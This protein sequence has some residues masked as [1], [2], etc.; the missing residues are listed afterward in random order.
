MKAVRIH[1][2][3]GPEGLVYE[4]LPDPQ[5]GPGQAIVR[6]EAIG[7]NFA[8]VGAR[9]NA[10]PANLPAPIGGEAAGVVLSVGEGVSGFQPGDRVAFQG[11]P[12][13][14]AE[15]VA[16]P[17]ARLVPVPEGITTKQAAA[18]LLQGMTAHYL[19]TDTYPL[20][21]GDTC[22]VHAAAGGVGL[23]LCQIARM[24]GAT[25]IGTVSSAA[26]AEAARAAG[27]HHTILYTEVD[28]AEEVKRL[29]DGRG[30]DVI[31]DSVGQT[32]FMKGFDCLRPRGMMVSYGQASGPVP[33]VEGALLSRGSFSYARAGLA[34]YTA[35]RAELLERAGE[36]FEWVASGK[37]NVHV[38]GEYPLADAGKAQTA[39]EQRETIGKLLLIP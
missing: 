31:Y 4:D 37:L 17:A 15:Q 7:M 5:A 18:V 21:A 26:K 10:S 1:A 16:A 19:A 39:L 8:E 38:F 35:T 2:A 11:A 28:F 36:V 12:G 30:A 29:T 32:T 13:A 34:A 33:A 23:L 27:A 3:G 22:V 20:K 9:K 25:V 6:I 24:R 14:Y